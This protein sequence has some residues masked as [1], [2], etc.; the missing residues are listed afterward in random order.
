MK[1]TDC[2][3]CHLFSHK[4]DIKLNMFSPAMLYGIGSQVSSTDIVTIDHGSS[5]NGPMK[6]EQKVTQPAC[7]GN[8]SSN[9]L[10]LSF[11]A[12]AR[13]GSLPA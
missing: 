5:M 2:T 7:L 9:S 13:N 3:N 11:G 12:G 1:N 10:I 8:H 6:L 4:M